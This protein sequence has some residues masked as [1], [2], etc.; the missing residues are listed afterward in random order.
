MISNLSYYCVS[1]V[2]QEKR[3]FIFEGNLNPKKTSRENQ[4]VIRE[5][6][7]GFCSMKRRI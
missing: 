5:G 4:V 3:S 1:T 6:G 2:S 7:M